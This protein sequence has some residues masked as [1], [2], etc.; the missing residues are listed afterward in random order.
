MEFTRLPRFSSGVTDG[1][2]WRLYVSGSGY[3]D[4]VNLDDLDQTN[5]IATLSDGKGFKNSF[6]RFT[7]CDDECSHEFHGYETY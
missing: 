4:I 1:I 5:G 7:T 3:T 6:A 2:R